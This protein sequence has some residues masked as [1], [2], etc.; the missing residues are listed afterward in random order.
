MRTLALVLLLF[1]ASLT[2][3]KTLADTAPGTLDLAQYQGKVVYLDFWASWC[4]PCRRSFPWMNAMQQK[5]SAQGLVIVSVNV[6]EKRADA[7]GFLKANPASFPV[8]FDPEG[9]LAEQYQLI[10]M[11]SSF[12]IGRDGKVLKAHQ[13]FLDDSPTRYEAELRAALGVP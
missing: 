8:I 13:G 3:A 9:K 2:G 10:G 11:P 6:D 7:D 1:A 5:Y 12:I 4:G